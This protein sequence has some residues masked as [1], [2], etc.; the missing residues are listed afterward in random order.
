MNIYWKE[1][2]GKV[3]VDVCATGDELRGA[4]SG[5]DGAKKAKS[6]IKKKLDS[7]MKTYGYNPN[8]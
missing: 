5:K 2:S 4:R 3:V 1:P 7:K 6:Y 8:S